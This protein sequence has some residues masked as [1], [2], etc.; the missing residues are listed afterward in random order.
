MKPRFPVLAGWLLALA[1]CSPYAEFTG[2]SELFTL[3]SEHVGDEFEIGVYL[4]RGYDEDQRARPVVYVLDG[5]VLGEPTAGIAEL[6]RLDVVVVGVGYDDGFSPDRRRRDYTPT[7]DDNYPMSGGAGEFIEF[8]T[9]ELI[10]RIEGDY[11]VDPARRSL[12]GH[13]QGGVGAMGFAFAQDP[14]AP[15]FRGI[16]AVSPAL[17]WDRGV[18]LDREAEYAAD[19]EAL[20]VRLFTSVAEFDPVPIWGYG[21]ELFDRLED[22]GY[23]GLSLRREQYD[24]VTHDTAWVAA[25]EDALEFLHGR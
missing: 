19:H 20:P 21:I 8:V 23:E 4:P 3:E 9:D 17:W 16:A 25:C 12:V 2:T 13:S 24:R 7:V 14:A 22:R 11:R 6:A 18:M 10:P 5:S 1:A 15:W